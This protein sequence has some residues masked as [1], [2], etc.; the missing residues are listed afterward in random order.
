LV[1]FLGE[2]HAK[3]VD[4]YLHQQGLDTSTPAS[5][6]M[7]QI[8]RVFIELERAVIVE[9]VSQG[10]GARE[11]SLAVVRWAARLSRRIRE[12][13]A[14]GQESSK[15][16]KRLASAPEPSEAGDRGSGN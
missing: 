15:R 5:K 1:A 13:L 9:P 2:L 11:G 7:F 12:Q 16:P 6:A 3:G 10:H 14:T 8:L 4:L